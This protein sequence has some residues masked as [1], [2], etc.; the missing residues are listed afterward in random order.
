M[1]SKPRGTLLGALVVWTVLGSQVRVPCKD[2]KRYDGC[3]LH[4]THSVPHR[5]EPLE[6][7]RGPHLFSGTDRHGPKETCNPFPLPTAIGSGDQREPGLFAR[8]KHHY[9]VPWQGLSAGS[10]SHCALDVNVVPS[11]FPAQT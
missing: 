3:V 5:R 11:R 10:L 7:T 6:F 9:V 2:A 4:A 8:A 1:S